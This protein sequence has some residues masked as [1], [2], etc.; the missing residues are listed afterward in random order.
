M[1]VGSKIREL[2]EKKSLSAKELAALVPCTPSFISQI[3]RGKSSPSVSTLKNIANALNINMVDFF[4]S[5]VDD[6]QVVLPV[7][8]RVHLKL[9]R[10]DAHLQSLTHGTGNKKMQVFYT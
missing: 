10:W 8:Q 5:P 3:E 9:P 4:S 6:N 1:D 2:R 7:N